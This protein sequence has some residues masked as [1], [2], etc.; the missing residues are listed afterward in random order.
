MYVEYVIVGVPI[1]N[2]STGSPALLAWRAAVEAEVKK[3]WTAAPLTG[4]LKAVIINFHTGDKPSLDLD[5]MS[6]RFWT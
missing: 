6:K 3:C 4:H 2:Q 1:S 5:N